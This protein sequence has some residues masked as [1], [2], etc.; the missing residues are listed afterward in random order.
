MVDNIAWSAP[1]ST[2]VLVN[3][4]TRAQQDAWSEALK[5]TPIPIWFETWMF[6]PSG[7]HYSP[8][9]C[10]RGDADALMQLARKLGGRARLP[11]PTPPAPFG[12]AYIAT[13][14]RPRRR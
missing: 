4:A 8:V 11:D 1:D 12:I 6:T 9:K 14:T 7:G 10:R 13:P 2:I 5:T 3:F